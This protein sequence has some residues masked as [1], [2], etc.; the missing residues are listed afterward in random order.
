MHFVPFAHLHNHSDFS[1]LGATT[2]VD[3]L[4]KQAAE[5]KQPAVAL[6]DYGN[7]FGAIEFYSKAMKMGIKPVLGC[8]VFLCPDHTQR[9]SEGPR[10]PRFPQLVLLARNNTGWKNLLKLISI[11]YIEGFY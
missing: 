7:L 9:V 6:T 3:D 5:L 1:L 2:R 10:G 11:S 8:E 4:L